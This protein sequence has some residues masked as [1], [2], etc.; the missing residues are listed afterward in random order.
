MPV[1]MISQCPYDG[2]NLAVYGIGE[3]AAKAGV[4]P[5]NDMTTETAVVKLMWALGKT[6]NMS[7][8]A[9][10]LESNI[11]DEITGERKIQPAD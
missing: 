6:Q 11:C 8:I 2:V 4:I 5:G 1:L 10:L 7:E 9:G 3:Q